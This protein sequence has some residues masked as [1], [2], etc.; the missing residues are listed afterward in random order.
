MSLLHPPT[1]I[2]FPLT[3]RDFRGPEPACH[4]QAGGSCQS[5]LPPDS[6]LPYLSVSLA[7]HTGSAPGPEGLRYGNAISL[8]PC[9]RC[10]CRVSLC[11]TQSWRIHGCTCALSAESPFHSAHSP[12]HP[13][14][15]PHLLSQP[16]TVPHPMPTPLQSHLH[17]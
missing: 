2:T 7:L 14:T 15:L 13:Q 5:F 8:Y 11:S 17:C 3:L 12:D 4:K 1:R 10:R 16:Q 6:D 9:C